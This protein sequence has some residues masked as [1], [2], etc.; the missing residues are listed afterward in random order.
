MGQR[1]TPKRKAED[2]QRR[3]YWKDMTE[4][5]AGVRGD[6]LPV[7]RAT[8]KLFKADVL[9]VIGAAEQLLDEAIDS[10]FEAGDLTVEDLHGPD[11]LR[12]LKAENDAVLRDLEAKVTALEEMVRRLQDDEDEPA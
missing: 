9:A 4:M 10:M 11:W 2:A 7:D 5:V 12:E 6:Q 1:W 3:A 8:G